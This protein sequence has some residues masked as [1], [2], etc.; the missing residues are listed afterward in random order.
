MTVVVLGRIMQE[1]D[2][3]QPST[4]T[5]SSLQIE[6]LLPSYWF[7]S[8]LF[9]VK[10][11]CQGLFWVS[12]CSLW[13]RRAIIGQHPVSTFPFQFPCYHPDC[14][15]V[16]NQSSPRLVSFHCKTTSGFGKTRTW[17]ETGESTVSP[18]LG[19]SSR[20]PVSLWHSCC[21]SAP[22]SLRSG[23]MAGGSWS[24]ALP[25]PHTAG[26]NGLVLITS[27]HLGCLGSERPPVDQ[28][29]GNASDGGRPDE[30]RQNALVYQKGHFH[31]S[32]RSRDGVSSPIHCENLVSFWRQTH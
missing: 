31:F 16:A 21:P 8:D 30:G 1:T 28:A 19:Q 29:L 26:L 17:M 25:F 18:G 20:E 23:K 7:I 4:Q 2:P 12:T 22:P 24:Y 14:Y 10:L 13:E 11:L 9:S 6:T 15:R 32:L 3:P 27:L 5:C